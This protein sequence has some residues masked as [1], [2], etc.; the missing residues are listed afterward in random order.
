M[1]TLDIKHM[2]RFIIILLLSKSFIFDDY[3]FIQWAFSLEEF[4]VKIKRFPGVM[5]QFLGCLFLAVS[6]P[7]L[8]PSS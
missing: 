5:G 1:A 3:Q 6:Y 8:L 4:G 2:G 7:D